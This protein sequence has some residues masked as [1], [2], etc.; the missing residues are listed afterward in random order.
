MYNDI[1]LSVLLQ[2]GA[3]LLQ[4]FTLG[5]RLLDAV[6]ADQPFIGNRRQQLL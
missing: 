6:A 1:Q 3:S 5:T 2:Q 4:V